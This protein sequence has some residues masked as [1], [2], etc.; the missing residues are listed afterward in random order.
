MALLDA[1]SVCVVTY[2]FNSH[3]VN[4]CSPTCMA[5]SSEDD[6]EETKATA[7]L[8]QRRPRVDFTSLSAE[9]DQRS[10]AADEAPLPDKRSRGRGPAAVDDDVYDIICKLLKG[11]YDSH[12]KKADRTRDERL[13]SGKK[14][15]CNSRRV[16]SNI[17]RCAQL[18]GARWYRLASAKEI[19]NPGCCPENL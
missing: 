18:F 2:A 7:A 8:V 6:F 12:T 14:Q 9:D 4:C 11:T 15:L 1:R 3:L 10:P 19:G 17:W 5:C 16:P 13:H